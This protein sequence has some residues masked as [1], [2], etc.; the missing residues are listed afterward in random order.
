M[1]HSVQPNQGNDQNTI[2][3]P[4]QIHLCLDNLNFN[5]ICQAFYYLDI[6]FGIKLLS[7]EKNLNIIFKDDVG[8]PAK[9]AKNFNIRTFAIG[10]GQADESEL[11]LIATPPFR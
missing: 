5:S 8:N 4:F 7:K 3:A 9:S 11:Q 1:T 2:L 6:T 10:V